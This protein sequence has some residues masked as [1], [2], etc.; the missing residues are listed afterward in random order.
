MAAFPY[1][2]DKCKGLNH[3]SWQRE[4]QQNK[5]EEEVEE[6]VEEEEE[7]KKERNL[8]KKHKIKL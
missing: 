8:R 2:G 4:K 6:E 1:K 3:P 7:R 5:E